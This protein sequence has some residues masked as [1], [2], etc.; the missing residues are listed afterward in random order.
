[1]IDIE[2]MVQYLVLANSHDFPSL[3]A[4]D[5]NIA[6]LQAAASHG[7]IPVQDAQNIRAAYR[8]FRRR[9]HALRL[10]GERYAR[11]P[12]KELESHVNATMTLWK[13]LFG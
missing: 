2:F 5:G 4:N 6:L 9:Q 11:V 12:A 1:M 3:Q 10:A 7:L 13:R 8:A